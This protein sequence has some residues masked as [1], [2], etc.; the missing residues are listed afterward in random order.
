MFHSLL[1][2]LYPVALIVFHALHF[3]FFPS[4]E[5]PFSV[6][7]LHDTPL[8]LVGGNVLVSDG[9]IQALLTYLSCTASHPR[10]LPPPRSAHFGADDNY[11]DAD[12]SPNNNNTKTTCTTNDAD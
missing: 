9:S 2:I 1:T 6:I 4:K 12:A 3:D 11:A 7:H 5:T 8:V 10:C